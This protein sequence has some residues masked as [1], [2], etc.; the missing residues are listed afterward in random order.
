MKERKNMM[1]NMVS[2]VF[3][4]FL[5]A[6]AFASNLITWPVQIIY[7]VIE[8]QYKKS[9]GPEELNNWLEDNAKKWEVVKILWNAAFCVWNYDNF[10]DSLMCINEYI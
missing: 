2:M 4:K 6:L 10:V 8:Y 9:K 1:K 3:I 5:I 7:V